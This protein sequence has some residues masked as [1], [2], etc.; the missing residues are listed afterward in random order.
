MFQACS[1]NVRLSGS[2]AEGILARM[3]AAVVSKGIAA[4]ALRTV[5]Q[6]TAP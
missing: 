1:P 3:E 4:T 5:G 2:V 6:G